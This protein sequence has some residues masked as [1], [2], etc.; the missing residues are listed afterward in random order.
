VNFTFFVNLDKSRIVSL[1]G[2]EVLV[3]FILP[4]DLDSAG[5]EI[6]NG[7]SRK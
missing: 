3:H 4:D 5:I 6:L 1:A 7:L 2:Q